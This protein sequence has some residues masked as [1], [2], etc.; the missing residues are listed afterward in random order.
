[1]GL[2][3]QGNNHA[4]LDNDEYIYE[5]S[6]HQPPLAGQ[7]GRDVI[8]TATNSDTFTG[9]ETSVISTDILRIPGSFG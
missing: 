2:S 5:K 8:E 9:M 7:A 1:L 6:Q 4:I 3:N